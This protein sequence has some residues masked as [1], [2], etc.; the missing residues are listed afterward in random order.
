MSKRPCSKRKGKKKKTA[1]EELVDGS[2]AAGILVKDLFTGVLLH[3]SPSS[4]SVVTCPSNECLFDD[5][6][7]VDMSLLMRCCSN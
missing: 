4:A 2:N 6:K 3:F 1:V 7:F 5:F